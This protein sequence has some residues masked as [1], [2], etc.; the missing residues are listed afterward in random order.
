[1]PSNFAEAGDRKNRII[2][3]AG[4]KIGFCTERT[5]VK[6]FGNAEKQK[7]KET[8]RRGF[9]EFSGRGRWGQDCRAVFGEW[10]V[11]KHSPPAERGVPPGSRDVHGECLPGEW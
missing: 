7:A 6:M 8:K 9:R 1:M 2:F 5:R 10:S 3:R 11:R 4:E